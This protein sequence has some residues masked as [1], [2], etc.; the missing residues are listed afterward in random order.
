MAIESGSLSLEVG[1]NGVGIGEDQLSA[2]G[3]L[4][5]LGMRERALLLGGEFVISGAPNGGTRVRVSVPL[6][7]SGN[8]DKGA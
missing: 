6:P 8:G 3:S 4:G 1:D 7:A 5:I 2:K